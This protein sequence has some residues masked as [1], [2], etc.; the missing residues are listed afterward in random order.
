MIPVWGTGA[1]LAAP[2]AALLVSGYS[3]GNTLPS[4]YWNFLFFH[5]SKEFANVLTAAN[6]TQNAGVDTQLRD[7][8]KAIGGSSWTILT[9]GSPYTVPLV[10][11]NYG[12]LA[13]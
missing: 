8:I 10:S 1:V 7:A 11:Q 13:T 5:I 4:Q 9:S 2:P 12:I 6:I 3:P